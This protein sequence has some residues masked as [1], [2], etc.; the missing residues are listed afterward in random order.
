MVN[1]KIGILIQKSESIFSNGCF[2]QAYFTYKTLKNTGHNVCLITGD[3]N[4]VKF[5]YPEIEI[6]KISI[7]NVDDISMILFVSAFTHDLDM[8]KQLKLKNIKLVNQIGGNYFILTQEKIIFNVHSNNTFFIANKYIDEVWLLPMYSFMKG[9][10]EVLGKRPVKVVPYVWDTEIVNEYCLRKKL[11][12]NYDNNIIK[13]KITFIIMEPNMSIH[14]TCLIPLVIIEGIYNKYKNLIDKVMCFCP[15][16]N[17]HF[18]N[19]VSDLEIGKDN[20]VDFYQRI[21]M[22]EVLEQAKKWNTKI[23]LVSHNILN[24]LNYLPMEFLYY[25]Y[26]V[27]HN[28]EPYS[29]LGYYYPEHDVEKGIELFEEIIN[30]HDINLNNNKIKINE[31]LH[32]FSP[33]NNNNINFYKNLLNN[34]VDKKE[35]NSD[36]TTYS[37]IFNKDLNKLEII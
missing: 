11:S 26:P 8:C 2:Q 22:P 9:Y 4:Y 19:F 7:D 21:I 13:N 25:G 36:K 34:L 30:K 31:S 32:R 28:C 27:I 12:I 33:D 6:R 18:N 15:P 17:E 3:E 23:I 1:K 5:D 20:K 35:N 37:F 16:D 14:K 29:N 24:N 10:L